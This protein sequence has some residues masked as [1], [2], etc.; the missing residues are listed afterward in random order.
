M[1]RENFSQGGGETTIDPFY[2]DGYGSS[3]QDRRQ[4]IAQKEKYAASVNSINLKFPLKSYKRGFFQGNQ[5]TI[6]SI[7]EDIKTLLLTTRGERVMHGEMGTNI[8]GREGS[9]FEPTTREETFES[10][11]LEVETAIQTYLPYIR[12]VNI[13]MI[14]QEEEP[15]LGNNKIRI[16][17]SYAIS[18]QNALVDNIN[19]TLN[20]P[21][22]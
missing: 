16:N 3:D 9:L 8:T 5:D 2:P 4:I 22:S 1:P 19:L 15:R 20:N 11:R 17:M 14:T 6:S 13:K 10:I 21:E 7:R 18:D 12:V